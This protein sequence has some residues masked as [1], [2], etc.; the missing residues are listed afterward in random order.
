MSTNLQFITS[1]SLTSSASTFSVTNCF[2]AQYDVY[3]ICVRDFVQ[4]NSNTYTNM[5][6]VDSGGN[7]ISDSE[8]ERAELQMASYASAEQ[9]RSTSASE[10]FDRLNFNQSNATGV[11]MTII[12]FNP[13]SSS[14]FTY[15]INQSLGFAASA[16]GIG[17]RGVAV[18]KSAESITGVS[19]HMDTG[20]ITSATVNVF[21]IK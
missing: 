15:A 3:K 16:G 5:R 20:N 7:V 21:G 10:L 14:D 4:A 19:F 8:Y 2:N 1:Q 9:T 18:H 13:F 6:L 17:F 11:G 12:V